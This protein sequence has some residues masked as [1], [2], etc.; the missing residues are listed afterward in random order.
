MPGPH[1]ISVT[2]QGGHSETDRFLVREGQAELT[3]LDPDEPLLQGLTRA[4]G[5]HHGRD[6]LEIDKLEL[7]DAPAREVLSRKDIPLWDR[8]ATLVALLV[9]LFAEWFLRRRSGLT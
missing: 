3:R 8:W 7:L 5:G 9:L 4:T 1:R 6:A 2:H